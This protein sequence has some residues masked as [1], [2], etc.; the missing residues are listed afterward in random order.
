MPLFCLGLQVSYLSLSLSLD[1]FV[2]CGAVLVELPV[3][4]S[5]NGRLT[6]YKQPLF[7]PP[8]QQSRITALPHSSP[9]LP[10]SDL[11]WVKTTSSTSTQLAS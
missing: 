11:C 10:C 4:V 8:S 2:R 7:R 1:G 5:A 6:N 3:Y 9:V